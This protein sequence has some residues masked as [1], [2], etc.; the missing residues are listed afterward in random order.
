[1]GRR[2]DLTGRSFGRLKVVGYAGSKYGKPAWSCICDCGVEKVISGNSLRTELTK[3]CGCYRKQRISEL[4]SERREDLTGKV[5]GRL[6]VIDFYGIKNQ[7]SYWLCKCS[8]DES[9]VIFGS[10]L[11][12]GLTVSCG[13]YQRELVSKMF[14]G[15][16]DYCG[17][18]NPNYKITKTDVERRDDRSYPEY[19]K[20]RIKV[21]ERDEYTCQFCGQFGGNLQS[22]HI[23]DY[24]NNP[25]LRTVLSNGVC[26]CKKHHKDFHSRYGVKINTRAQL[27]QFL[28]RGM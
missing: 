6:E 27:Y 5:F 9:K 21:F 11:K 20:W 26:L 1:M 24:V 7:K 23:E 28:M 8:C 12:T 17:V 25:G 15:R 18:N 10:S 14:K 16:T 13:C 22:H 3:S 4:H 2:I 19:K